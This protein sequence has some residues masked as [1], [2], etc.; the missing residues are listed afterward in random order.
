MA[1]KLPGQDGTSVGASSTPNPALPVSVMGSTPVP[2]PTVLTTQASEK[3]VANLKELMF[4]QVEALKE[5]LESR[6]ADRDRAI[7]LLQDGASALP[8][9]L[10]E[11]VDR[12]Q[13]LHEQRF[14]VTEEKFK[15]IDKQFA[16]RD[17]RTELATAAS[18]KAIDAAL[19]AQKEAAVEQN[20]SNEAK[21][22]K[23]EAGFT[24][25]IDQ[26]LDLV[27]AGT[28]AAD[29]KV[30]DLKDRITKMEA[31]KQGGSDSWASLAGVI[32]ACAGVAAII[33]LLIAEIGP[34]IAH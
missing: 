34:R 21:I 33:G 22:T 32:G 1:T 8:D 4:T 16:E 25:Q 24:K 9:M 14:N 20:R 29:D 5:L 19:S 26:L 6:F 17:T 2:D 30:A 28:K 23:S 12:L 13:E 31:M 7:T 11:R 10:S 27:K 15:S 3:A 18:T